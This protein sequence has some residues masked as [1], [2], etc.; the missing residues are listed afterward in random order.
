MDHQTIIFFAPRMIHTIELTHANNHTTL[1]TLTRVSCPN[2]ELEKG[3]LFNPTQLKNEFNHMQNKR[4]ITFILN[5]RTCAEN[6]VPHAQDKAAPEHVGV[7]S[8]PCYTGDA[9]YLYSHDQ[10]HYYYT[11]TIPR[12]IIMQYWL[13]AQTLNCTVSAIIPSRYAL[14][15]MYKK[16]HGTA[17]RT[18]QLGVDMHKRNNQ[19]EQLFGKDDVARSIN[20]NGTIIQPDDYVPLLAACG[21]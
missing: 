11:C 4:A 21:L 9:Q 8:S 17:F 18:A 10:A 14:L 16:L 5:S 15:R 3:I 2:A 7:F 6:I 12:A 20:L 13:F 1:Q 19:I